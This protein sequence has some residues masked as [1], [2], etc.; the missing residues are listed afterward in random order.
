MRPFG[1]A[2][3]RKRPRVPLSLVGCDRISFLR[4][5]AFTGAARADVAEDLLR[6][7]TDPRRLGRRPGE[8]RIHGCGTREKLSWPE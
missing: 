4:H 5:Y 1:A 7:G 6:L 8:G 2:A 3:C